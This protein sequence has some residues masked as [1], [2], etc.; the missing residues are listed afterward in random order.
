MQSTTQALVLICLRFIPVLLLLGSI[1]AFFHKVNVGPR[2]LPRQ[3]PINR[4]MAFPVFLTSVG[5][6]LIPIPELPGTIGIALSAIGIV[7][8][9]ILF[10][11]AR[12]EYPVMTDAEWLEKAKSR[13]GNLSDDEGKEDPRESE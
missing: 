2:E 5:T 12:Q 1:F 9:S 8:Y 7:W 10:K 6:F 3:H 11:E 13:L 4:K